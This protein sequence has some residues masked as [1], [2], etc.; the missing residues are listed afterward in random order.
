VGIID[1]SQE[2]SSG[3]RPRLRLRL[4]DTEAR[5]QQSAVELTVV[6]HFVIHDHS[7]LVDC[8]DGLHS[9]AAAAS[10]L[11]L[12]RFPRGIGGRSAGG[13]ACLAPRI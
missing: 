12:T 3:S 11:D 7:V 10:I 5:L 2:P 4:S 1:A 9:R 6:D 13:L 8:W